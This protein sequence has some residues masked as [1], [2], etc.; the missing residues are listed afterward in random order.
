MR[1]LRSNH[2][3]TTENVE[4]AES[5]FERY[6]GRVISVQ[7]YDETIAVSNSICRVSHRPLVKLLT[8]RGRSENHQLAPF[9]IATGWTDIPLRDVYERDGHI[10]LPAH[11]FGGAYTSAHITYLAGLDVI[12]EDVESCVIEI[13]QLVSVGTFDELF[14]ASALSERAQTTIRTYR[15]DSPSHS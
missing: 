3:F 6:V 15:G 9:A 13:A 7:M 12:P 1:Y 10:A 11:L 4:I 14:G 8:V 5:L 2:G